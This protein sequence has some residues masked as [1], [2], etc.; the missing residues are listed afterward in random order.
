LKKKLILEKLNL[1]KKL[2]FLE[3]N[4]MKSISMELNLEKKQ[5]AQT[6]AA[7]Q[8]ITQSTTQPTQI[9]PLTQS[10]Q[11]IQPAAVS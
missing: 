10:T 11:A 3:L 8:L 2:V 6:A 7:T 9:Q 5:P 1:K 4:L